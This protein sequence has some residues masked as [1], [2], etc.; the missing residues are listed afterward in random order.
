MG[1]VQSVSDA[2]DDITKL[3]SENS[4]ILNKIIQRGDQ[5][6]KEIETKGYDEQE[7]LCDRL[8]YHYIDELNDL[9][10]TVVMKGLGDKIKLGL[11]PRETESMQDYKLRICTNVVNFHLQ[12]IRTIAELNKS[13]PYCSKMEKEI[14][15]GLSEKS[16]KED[17]NSERWG[18]VYK[19]VKSFNYYIKTRYNK[20]YTAINKI[21]EAKNEPSLK[22]AINNA[23]KLMGDTNVRC[24]SYKNELFGMTKGAAQVDNIKRRNPE[25]PQREA[26]AHDKAVKL[27]EKTQESQKSQKS[28]KQ[29]KFNPKS[30]LKKTNEPVILSK[31]EKGDFVE[32]TKDYT[33]NDSKTLLPA[34]LGQPVTKG[35]VLD[36]EKDDGEWVLV[37]L[38]GTRGYVPRSHLKIYE[39]FQ[40]NL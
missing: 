21:R 32:L 14:F 30:I 11:S 27:A 15:A 28:Q 17:I 33:R 40:V 26:T 22:R 6:V 34:V 23:N 4:D 20:I 29:V 36:V 8:Q 37:T 5:I 3:H 35:V 12:K 38:E 25:P 13:L 16:K 10:S 39:T 7:K 31:L 9:F 2:K 18:K 1:G 24:N 19:E